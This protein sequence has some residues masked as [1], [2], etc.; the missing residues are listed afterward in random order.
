[1][2][3]PFLDLLRKNKNYRRL[4]S[5]F[6]ISLMGD[7][8]SMM[9]VFAL[10]NQIHGSG[11]EMMGGVLVLKQLPIFLISPVA[12]VVADRFS[13][14]KI[15]IVSDLA[16]F[17]AVLL[18]TLSPLVSSIW[19]VY[20]ILVLQ[21]TLAAF[22]EPARSALTPDIVASEDLVT[23]NAFSSALWSMMLIFGAALGGVVTELIGWQ[24]AV[25]V[26]AFT[27]LASAYFISLIDLPRKAARAKQ[28]MRGVLLESRS[29]LGKFK[30]YLLSNKQVLMLAMI[31][32]VYGIGGAMILMLTV[33]GQRVYSV[34]K[35]GAIGVSILYL[36]RG[37]GALMGPLIAR[38]FCGNDQKKMR[39]LLI[40]CFVLQGMAYASFGLSTQLFLACFFVMC[41]HML[42][43]CIWV[44]STVLLQLNADTFFRG[45]VFGLEF[46]LFTLSFSASTM[47]YGYIIDHQI[48][49]PPGATVLLG[50]SWIISA[51]WWYWA[52]RF[53]NE[54]NDLAH[55]DEKV[56]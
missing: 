18:L 5:A 16:R 53:W 31:K 14:R 55:Y 42:A 13:R 9:A 2:E 26:D 6:G 12:G 51:I 15:M 36:A 27:Y 38:S 29:D 34:G 40:Y 25:A 35:S 39:N 41:A 22:F 4:T 21:A 3:T 11:A 30:Q 32:G 37:L 19:Y 7:W 8:F 43:S 44:L 54:K 47:F 1:V 23:A 33:F 46:G 24:A 48:L 28:S 56:N 52:Q 20:F 17:A 50:A 49:A 45:R 10:I